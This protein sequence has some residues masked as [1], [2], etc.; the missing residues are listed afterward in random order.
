MT[1]WET[2]MGKYKIWFFAGGETRNEVFN[3]FTG[4]FIRLMREICGPYF[5]YVKGV[6]FRFPAQNVIWALNNAQKPIKF[7]SGNSFVTKACNQILNDNISPD[8]TLILISS[9]SGSII[10]AQT[11]CLLARRISSEGILMKPF[12]LALGSSMIATDSQLFLLLSEF[13]DKGLIG[14]IIL[15]ELHDA[16]DNTSGMGGRSK[17]EAYSNAFGLMIPALSSKY[18]GPSFLNTNPV[19][20]H[21]HRR[22]SQTVEKAIDFIRI[23]LVKNRLGGEEL[24]LKAEELIKKYC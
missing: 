4:S 16:D 24:G 15:D 17:S 2:Q 21:I 6:Y 7:V 23:I 11:A 10:A 19:N 14:N 8:T 9:S 20:G 18:N 13:K 1:N 22:R 12:H 5:D 3:V